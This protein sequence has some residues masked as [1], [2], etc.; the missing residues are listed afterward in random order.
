MHNEFM[1]SSFESPSEREHLSNDVDSQSRSEALSRLREVE[2]QRLAVEHAVRTSLLWLGIV[3]GAIVGLT[4]G[5]LATAITIVDQ[6]I[7]DFGFKFFRPDL[8]GFIRI[9]TAYLI[10]GGAIGGCT[11]YYLFTSRAECS[12]V[13]RWL[14][15]TA[16]YMIGTPLL[17]GLLLPLTLFFFVDIFEGLRPGLWIS[18]FVEELLGSFLNGYIFMVKTLYAGV[19]GAIIYVAIMIGTYILALRRPAGEDQDQ[20]ALSR[21]GHVAI[22]ALV[23]LVPLLILAFGPFTLLTSITSAIT[24]ERL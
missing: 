1:D 15:A 4:V 5:Y 3:V 22:A 2:N 21:Y 19:A 10:G 20:K 14:L 7:G 11:S 12:S 18:A 9:A 8:L 17:I 6:N 13:V 16:I 24:G 23:A